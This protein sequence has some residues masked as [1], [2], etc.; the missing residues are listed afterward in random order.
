MN[1]L[2]TTPRAARALLL[3][4][5]LVVGFHL[6]VLTGVIPFGIV[7]GGRLQSHEQMVQFET[8]SIGLNLLMLA[9]VA[10]AAGLLRVPLPG[11]VLKGAL[12]L[13]TALFLL[14]TVGNVLAAT[15][16]ERLLFTPL[17]LLLAVLSCRLALGTPARA[18]KA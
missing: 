16:L 15:A 6:L 2:L 1:N 3:I 4:L 12:W 13:M 10:A 14:N 8:V 9:V 18:P 7:W 5:A 11:L 17:T